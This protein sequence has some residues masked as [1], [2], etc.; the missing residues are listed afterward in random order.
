MRKVFTR[1]FLAITGFWA[2]TRLLLDYWGYMQAIREAF[3]NRGPIVTA[4]APILSS[5]WLPVCLFLVGALVWFYVEVGRKWFPGPKVEVPVTSVSRPHRSLKQM[6]EEQTI[7]IP[8][9]PVKEGFRIEALP[10]VPDVLNLTQHAWH[11]G[12]KI[13]F[14]GDAVLGVTNRLPAQGIDLVNF[15][16]LSISPPMKAAKGHRPSTLDAVLKRVDFSED[17]PATAVAGKTNDVRLFK[18]TR[19]FGVEGLKD[20]AIEFYGKW[21]DGYHSTFIPS[22]RHT[23]V[24][25][26][27]GS[28]VSRTEERFELTF[29][30]DKTKPVFTLTKTT[31]YQDSDQRESR[32]LLIAIVDKLRAGVKPLRALQEVDADGLET[33]EM[34]IQLCDDLVKYG[35]P[36]PFAAIKGTIPEQNWLEFLLAARLEGIDLSDELRLLDLLAAKSPAIKPIAADVQYL[37]R[38]EFSPTRAVLE[39][40]GIE[41]F[42][43]AIGIRNIGDGTATEMHCRGFVWDENLKGD[44]RV[45]GDALAHDVSADTY[46]ESCFLAR[47]TKLNTLPHFVVL[48]LEYKPNPELPVTRQTFYFKFRGIKDGK[49]DRVLLIA[50]KNEKEA[51]ERRFAEELQRAGLKV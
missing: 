48:T 36:H 27:T 50:T 11:E 19:P 25:E 26:V 29:S 38:A 2:A 30:I 10:P 46:I 22:E 39:G 3:E 28:G 34:L 4:L 51:I 1:I 20:I 6:I 35:H 5:Q 18:A 37:P 40:D 42:K 17:I 44:L 45:I 31:R 23:L 12:A 14:T 8:G 7:S 13:M 9:S 15:R 33:N 47:I 41:E 24:V 49:F 32:A 43:F 16:L 21:P